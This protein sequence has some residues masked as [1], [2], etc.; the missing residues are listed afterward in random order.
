MGEK[1]RARGT[2]TI[3]YNK[4]RGV[5][6][7]RIPI[8]RH[9][10][11]ET[12]YLTRT[13]RTQREV[14]AAL[15]SAGPPGPTTTVAEWC[16]RWLTT[17]DVRPG[18][19]D[20]YRTHV[21]KRIVPTLGG[22]QVRELASHHIEGAVRKWTCAA[23][24]ARNGLAVLG[25]C[26]EAACKVGLIERNPLD[27]A[28]KP[29]EVKKKIDPFT[30]AEIRRIIAEGSRL[31]TYRIFVV[32]ACTGC[33]SGEAM[34]LDVKDWDAA[35]RTL[36]I[37]KTQR[38][39]GRGTGPPK[40]SNSTRTIEVPA[41]AIPVIIA[42]IEGRTSGP[43]FRNHEGERR[44]HNGLTKPWE[45]LLSRLEITHRNPHQ[46]RHSWASHAIAAGIP[47]PDI[48]AYLGDTPLTIMKTYVHPTG[49][50][51]AVVMG[52]LF[53]SGTAPDAVR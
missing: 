26:L 30:V 4:R 37:H 47:I 19:E 42:E 1:R 31:P 12:Q 25:I 18:S 8:G 40:S 10:N 3:F 39:L 15:K 34:G 17:I 36:H 9:I 7:G 52:K 32:M 48:A 38:R 13:G 27:H 29:K 5:W 11:G 51:P 46:L 21:A 14:I 35:A 28:K 20:S 33:R 41:D 23:N 6:V 49:A 22:V 53:A 16:A 44:T 2:G 45:S 24:T 43:L 50:S